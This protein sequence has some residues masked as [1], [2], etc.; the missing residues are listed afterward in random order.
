[1]E[2]EHSF[3]GRDRGVMADVSSKLISVAGLPVLKRIA[4]PAGA[5]LAALAAVVIW[6]RR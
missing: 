2:L 4:V 1:M 3:A 6:R 5:R